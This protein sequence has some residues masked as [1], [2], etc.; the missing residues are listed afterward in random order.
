MLNMKKISFG[1]VALL[2]FASTAVFAQV[3]AT[4]NYCSPVDVISGLSGTFG[5]LRSNHFHSG[6]DIRTGGSVGKNIYSIADG[7]VSRISVSPSGFGKALYITHPDGKMSVYAHLMQ[8]NDTIAQWV[9]A[10]QYRQKSFT[11]NVFLSPNQFPVKKGALIALSGNSGSSGGPHLHFELRD[12]ATGHTINALRFGFTVPDKISPT[13][14]Q[15]KITPND[16]HSSVKHKNKS[17]VKMARG[18]GCS[19]QLDGNDTISV[20]GNICFGVDAIDRSTGSTNANGIYSFKVLIDDTLVFFEKMDEFSFDVTRDINSF[21]DYAYYKTNKTRFIQTKKTSGNRLKIYDLIV[22]DGVYNFED[23][24]THKIQYEVGD[25][26]ENISKLTFWIKSEKMESTASNVFGTKATRNEGVTITENQFIIKVP[27]FALYEDAVLDY[28]VFNSSEQKFLSPIFSIGNATIPL[29]KKAEITV[30]LDV[31]RTSSI[32]KNKLVLANIDGSTPKAVSTTRYPLF[33]TARIYD[34]G[35]YVVMA[36]TVAPVIKQENIWNNKDVSHQKT[37]RVKITDDFSGIANYTGTLN[38]QWILMD[39][40]AKEHLL[41]YT[42]DK[43]MKAGDN[44]FVLHVSDQVGNS[45]KIEMNLK[46]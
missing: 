8:F 19:Y 20:W 42:F 27:P 17:I 12:I 18:K 3:T 29:Q 26:A 41:E 32:N 35:K 37:I 6:I 40:D 16:V 21:I 25:I 13:I 2:F 9:R 45:S 43:L 22:S 15:I 10:E 31:S 30:F 38:G 4:G 23:G 24:R 1:L 36:D 44:K 28:S 5:E 33:L 46:F 39:Y 14:R 11:I 7:Y 34:F